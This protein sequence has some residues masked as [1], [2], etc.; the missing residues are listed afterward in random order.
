MKTLAKYTYEEQMN[1]VTVVKI[2]DKKNSTQESDPFQVHIILGDKIRALES[3]NKALDDNLEDLKDQC[4]QNDKDII[5]LK[6]DL[7]HQREVNEELEENLYRKIEDNDQM[8]EDLKSKE[9]EFD[10]LDIFIKDIVVEISQLRENN[11]SMCQ[12]VFEAIKLE[13]KVETQNNK[14]KELSDKLKRIVKVENSDTVNEIKSLKDDINR[15]ESEN[16]EKE[17]MLKK[18]IY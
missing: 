13:T 10:N 2:L 7:H 12:Q 9:E 3:N 17:I 5:D 14:I 1:I 18:F 8:K 4:S 15:L 6:D 11:E 16:K